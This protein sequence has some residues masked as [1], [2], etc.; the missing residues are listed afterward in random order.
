[1]LLRWI[2]FF[3]LTLVLGACASQ[4]VGSN[5]GAAYKG[6]QARVLLTSVTSGTVITS[7]S[8]HYTKLYEAL[9]AEAH[10]LAGQ[11]RNNFV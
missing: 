1:M 7:Y 3:F 2:G 4:G 11:A 9:E 10:E 6:G 8:I 5:G